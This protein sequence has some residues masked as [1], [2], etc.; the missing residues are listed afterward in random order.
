MKSTTIIISGAVI[1]LGG[2]YL[3]V[4]EHWEICGVAI[5]LGGVFVTL[6]GY[7]KAAAA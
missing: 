2:G 3:N 5:C 7:A 4:Y 6:V 1:A